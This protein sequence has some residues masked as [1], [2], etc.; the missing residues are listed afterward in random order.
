MVYTKD[1][2]RVEGGEKKL[3]E[4]G[5]VELQK[6]QGGRGRGGEGEERQAL[7]KLKRPW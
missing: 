6:Y 2:K 4:V 7:Q 3:C 1:D 5:S